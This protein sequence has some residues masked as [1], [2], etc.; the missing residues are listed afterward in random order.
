MKIGIIGAMEVEVE[1]LK[2]E[3]EGLN[4]TERSGMRFF[5]GR[6]AGADVVV[7]QCGIGKVNAAMCAQTLI[8]ELHA[9]H[10]INTG[11]AGSLDDAIEIGDLVV[12]TD[13]IHHDF[14]LTPLGYERAQVPGLDCLT[15]E[16]DDE[17]RAA[18]VKAAHEVAPEIGVFEGRVASGDQFVGDAET[19]AAIREA[20]GGLCCEMEGASIAHVCHRNG[21][22]FVIVRAISDKANGSSSV[23]YPTFEREAAHH[24]AS[25]TARLVEILAAK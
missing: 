2:G 21:V 22:P 9:T 17:L 16:A 15:F 11:V 19:K 7:V 3:L 4:V 12:S 5:E 8:G 13:A 10:V 20:F 18:V 23:D 25:I 14:D 1:T 6:L 24:C